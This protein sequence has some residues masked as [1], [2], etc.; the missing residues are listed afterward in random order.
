MTKKFNKLDTEEGR[1]LSEKEFKKAMENGKMDCFILIENKKGNLSLKINGEEI[2]LIGLF[3]S[4]MSAD[5]K[6]R[7]LI[8]HMCFHYKEQHPDFLSKDICS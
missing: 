6:F 2:D 5:K 8:E 1:E 7:R 3:M 4:I